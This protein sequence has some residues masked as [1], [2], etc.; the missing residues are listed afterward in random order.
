MREIK[1][2]GKIKFDDSEIVRWVYGDKV[3][4]GDRAFIFPDDCEYDNCGLSNENY[5]PVISGMVEVIPETVGQYIGRKDKNGVEIYKGT[6]LKDPQGNI[7]VVFYCE[8]QS[9]YFV[10]W[11]RKDGTWETDSC[12]GYGEVIGNVHDNPELL[13]QK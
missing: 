1:F 3:S 13:E 5:Q 12:I 11:H 9:K 10:N 4:V 6:S 8:T 2:R 7:G